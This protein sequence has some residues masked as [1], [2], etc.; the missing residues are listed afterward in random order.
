MH[1]DWL[2]LE[3][4]IPDDAQGAESGI[5]G[6]KGKGYLSIKIIE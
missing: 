6:T 1:G 4:N 3:N 5:V 2:R